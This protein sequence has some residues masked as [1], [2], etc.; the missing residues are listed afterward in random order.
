MRHRQVIRK[1]RRSVVAGSAALAMVAVGIVTPTAAFA[2]TSKPNVDSFTI[3]KWLAFPE[4]MLCLKYSVTGTMTYK[5]VRYGPIEG[6][7]DYHLENLQVTAP[8]LTVTAY[9][10]D[11]ASHGCTRK[12]TT[13]LKLQVQHAYKGYGCS[14]NPS[15]SVQFPFAVGVGFWPSCGEKKLGQWTSDYGAAGNWTQYNSSARIHFAQ[16]SWY[17][18]QTSPLPKPSCYG[19]MVRYHVYVRGIDDTKDT[20][21][22]AI[23]PTPEW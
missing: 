13:W 6:Y 16:Q 7:I 4:L 23:C 17:Q 5:A 1:F 10:Y 3:S 19:V 14:F 21:Q 18:S 22:F 9:R 20:G 12:S 11:S 15:I 2:N 8:K